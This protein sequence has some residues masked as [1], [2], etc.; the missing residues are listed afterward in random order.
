MQ[1]TVLPVYMFNEIPIKIP[2]TFFTE[3]KKTQL[4]KNQH[5]SEEMGTWIE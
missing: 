5:S 3:L 2:V 1:V 4:Q